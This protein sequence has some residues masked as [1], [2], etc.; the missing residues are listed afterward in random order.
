MQKLKLNVV[1]LSIALLIVACGRSTPAAQA[2]AASAATAAPIA[3]P[4]AAPA[5]ATSMPAD[6]PLSAEEGAEEASEEAAG[7]EAQEE[8]AEIPDQLFY[9]LPPAI[10]TTATGLYASPN[11]ADYI[12]PVPIPAGERVFVL[13]RNATSSHLRVVWNTGVG[14][15]PIS[16]TD[17]N[18]KR[19]RLEP[20]PV[21]LREPPACTKYITTQFGLRSLWTSQDQQRIAIIVDLFRSQ[22]GDFP[23]SYLSL[24]VNG[25]VVES[26][27]REIVE[28]GQ[29]S[30]KDVVLTVPQDL[31]PGDTVEYLLETTSDEPLS[32]AATIFAI[33]GDCVWEV[34]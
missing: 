11:L 9:N 20:L 27:R 5:P 16:F 2:P 13:G 26:S 14:W 22:Y 24:V 4:P 23:P 29:F 25:V 6:T 1:C 17:Y 19:E 32:F 30:L 21:F 15:V 3:N 12:V 8:T 18:G 10:L 7:E 33:P 34:D 28:R 31:L